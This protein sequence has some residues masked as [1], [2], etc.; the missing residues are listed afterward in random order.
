MFYKSTRITCY[1]CGFDH[2]Y[3]KL[4]TCLTVGF[5]LLFKF[6]WQILN[7]QTESVIFHEQVLLSVHLLWIDCG[8][9]A[10]LFLL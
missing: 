5:G 6:T 9:R 7:S 1:V 4:S 10:H 3:S 8:L 2:L